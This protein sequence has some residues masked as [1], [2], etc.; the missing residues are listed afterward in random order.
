METLLLTRPERL[1]DHAE[2]LDRVPASRGVLADPYDSYAW[3]RSWL[4]ADPAGV[5]GLACPMVLD[6]DGAVAALPMV[7][8]G[9]EWRMAGAGWRPRYRVVC[10]GERPPRE[11]IARLA[12]AALRGGA[13]RIQLHGMPSADPATVALRGAFAECGCHVAL[14]EGSADCVSPVEGGWDVHRKRFRK[15]ERTVKN[16]TNKARRLGPV[17]VRE[18]MSAAGGDPDSAWRLYEQ[19]HGRGW[20]GPLREPMREHRRRL[21]ER[22][23]ARGWLRV[24]SLAVAEAPA[25]A[26]VWVRIGPVAVAYSTVYDARLAALSAGTIAM[27]RSHELLSAEGP[28]ALFDYL[29]GRGPQKDQLGLERVPLVNL[30]VRRPA[31]I[32]V[33]GDR[34][35]RVARALARRARRARSGRERAAGG[36]AEGHAADELV[37]GLFTGGT[38]GTDTAAPAA[39][40]VHPRPEQ[41]LFLAVCGGHASVKRM[42]A[43]WSEGDDWWAVGSPVGALART[44]PTAADGTVPV[45]EVVLVA[46]EAR[47]DE[48]LRQLAA[49]RGAAL[50]TRPEAD[51]SGAIPVHRAP[52]PWPAGATDG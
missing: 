27:W 50:E 45:R 36:G 49:G 19:L 30:V 2:S 21:F 43:A 39:E 46:E 42:R 15:Y 10:R 51:R 14:R 25:A 28:V 29:P 4:D 17:A 18:E 12:E 47:A 22:W 26:I 20:K 13:R 48:V 16:F 35:T 40:R 24:Y 44:G 8:R 41:E 11:A 9:S 5:G 3:L 6:E 38:A 31:W 7:A 37:E 32:G 33:L 34:F 52:F 1:E 23:A